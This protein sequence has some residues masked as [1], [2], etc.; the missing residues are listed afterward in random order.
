M[1]DLRSWSVSSKAQH[2]S[3]TGKIPTS[4]RASTNTD[5]SRCCFRISTCAMHRFWMSGAV[6]GSLR[7]S[8]PCAWKASSV[9]IWTSLARPSQSRKVRQGSAPVF[10]AEA[11]IDSASFVAGRL[12]EQFWSSCFDRVSSHV[13]F[14]HVE[15]LNLF[16]RTL[17]SVTKPGGANL[18][19]VPNTHDAIQQLLQTSLYPA[20]RNLTRWT[21]SLV[22]RLT[23]NSKRGLKR[24]GVLFSP[25]THSEFIHDFRDQFGIYS[26]E[27]SVN[28]LM[29]A[30][31]IVRDIK[32]VR[33]IAYAILV[34]KPKSNHDVIG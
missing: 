32:P 34:E 28:P 10:F 6:S 1:A 24:H 9:S 5:C 8:P 33:E 3:S 29:D 18:Q 17:Y 16:C 13:V 27:R 14:E 31:F 12:E 25:A 4:R 15:D 23:S 11:G 20:P 7:P 2:P 21:W 30:G 26:L 19:V 22:K